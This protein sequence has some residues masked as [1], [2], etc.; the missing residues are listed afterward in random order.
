M[1]NNLDDYIF[2]H[3][4]L[5]GEEELEEEMDYKRR[6]RERQLEDGEERWSEH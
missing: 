1:Q 2:T 4:T 6:K 5:A 3:H